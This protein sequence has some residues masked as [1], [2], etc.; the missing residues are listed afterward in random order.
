MYVFGLML[1]YVGGSH[2]ENCLGVVNVK[3]ILS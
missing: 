2:L 1:A 3:F